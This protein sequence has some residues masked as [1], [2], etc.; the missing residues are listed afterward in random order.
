[1]YTLNNNSLYLKSCV[2]YRSV[3]DDH[4]FL[5]NLFFFFKKKVARIF[6]QHS[7]HSVTRNAFWNIPSTMKE[8]S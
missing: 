8:L 7:L 5:Y 6:M 4:K 2:L 3:L 1:M